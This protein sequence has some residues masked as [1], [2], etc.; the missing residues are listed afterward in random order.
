MELSA[1]VF[2]THGV[3]GKALCRSDLSLNSRN[4]RHTSNLLHLVYRGVVGSI[5]AT[6]GQ[7]V[8]KEGKRHSARKNI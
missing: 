1:G 8:K 6:S 4:P 3:A 7:S 2:Y 5:I